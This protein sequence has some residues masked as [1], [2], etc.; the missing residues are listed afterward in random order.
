MRMPLPPPCPRGRRAG[1]YGSRVPHAD[2]DRFDRVGPE[3][4]RDPQTTV[5]TERRESALTCRVES[6]NLDLVA[7]EYH[8]MTWRRR[9]PKDDAA[10]RTGR[11][12]GSTKRTRRAGAV[13]MVIST[14]YGVSLAAGSITL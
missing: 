1:R 6:E 4:R 2:G 12:S 13:G 8:L 10:R 7:V 11:P 9:H 5:G 3:G 14:L